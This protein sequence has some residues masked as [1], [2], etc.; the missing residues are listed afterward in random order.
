M[1]IAHILLKTNLVKTKSEARRAVQ[2][3]AIKIDGIL[4][5]DPFAQ[6]WIDDNNVLMIAERKPEYR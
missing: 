2:G 4:I 3:N 1:D 6:V 5:Q